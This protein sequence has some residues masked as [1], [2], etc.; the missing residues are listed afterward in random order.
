MADR[1][2]RDGGLPR[3]TT[4]I[5]GLDTVLYG[6]LLRG[7]AYIVQGRPG[8]GKTILANQIC[9]RH[10]G[11]GGRA[12]Y[13]TLLAESHARLLQHV[14]TLGFY[15]AA[16]TPERLAYVS[17]LKALQEGGLEGLLRLLRDEM[18]AHAVTLLV[19]DGF[20]TVRET[21]QSGVDLKSFLHRLQTQASFAD[22]TVLLLTS[23]P[24]ADA[25][26]EHTVVDGVIELAREAAG[27]RSVRRLTVAKSRGSATL[28]GPHQFEITQGGIVV[29]PRLEAQYRRPTRSDTTETVRLSSG[30]AALDG[31]LRGGIPARSMTL[32][33][34]PSGSGKTSLGLH[35][36]AQARAAEP[37]LHFGCYES[38]ARL[39]AK[40]ASL[41]LDLSARRR[42]GG[43]EIIWNPA[44]ENLLDALGQQLL[45]AVRRRGVRRLFIDGYGA[46]FRASVHPA[47][48][49]AFFTAL[50]NELRALGCT[51][52]ATWESRELIGPEVSAPV[53]ELSSVVENLVL[54][55]FVELRSELRR[56]ISIVKVR[57]SDF[58]GRL[59]ELKITGHGIE[60]GEAFDGAE[61]LMSGFARSPRPPRG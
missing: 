39:E 5:D 52:V 9:Y 40:A 13:V 56:L 33:L 21:A 53:P 26:P 49:V 44:T 61:A 36:L 20:L 11:D 7:G 10:A 54:T 43:V 17:G 15:D 38:P 30:V 57:E 14:S 31:M 8:A 18:T 55:R 46:F 59:R 19:L 42:G 27:V 12:L 47:R 6:G 34:G 1:D 2:A 16:L 60:I 51:T 37:G 23:T 24:T 48:M 45:D 41:G 22:C 3:L 29:H 58:D 35:F 32:V 4:G 25:S 50:T 28:D